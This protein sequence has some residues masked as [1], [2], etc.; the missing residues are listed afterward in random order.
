MT[1]EDLLKG[2]DITELTDDEVEE[3]I[4]DLTPD[5]AAKA[6][7]AVRK[8]QPKRNPTKAE[9]FVNALIAQ[10]LGEGE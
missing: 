9:D 8:R 4:K 3:L 2:K 6:I 7:R 10:K 5:E 1:L